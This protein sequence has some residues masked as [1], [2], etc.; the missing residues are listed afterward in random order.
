MARPD[1]EADEL[2]QLGEL[3]FDRRTGELRA[4]DGSIKRLPPQ[5]T[6]LLALLID[7]RGQVATREQIRAHLWPDVAV[8]F[9][10]GLHQCIR[11]IRT[12][13]GDDAK[14]PRFVET[15]PRRGYRLRAEPPPATVSS[16]HRGRVWLIAALAAIAIAAVLYAASRARGGSSSE[17][18]VFAIMSFEHGER[19][20]GEISERILVEL[21]AR[22]PAATVVGPRTT[23]PLRQRGH[24]LREIGAATSATYLINA[25]HSVAAEEPSILVE[26]IRQSDGKHIW[27]RRYEGGRDQ[28]APD[29]IGAAIRV[30]RLR[31]E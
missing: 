12:A 27:V 25:R 19:G 28:I 4:E 2:V 17:V 5:P 11:Q 10:A 18:E 29:V 13:L 20:G 1:A 31:D 3:R 24:S 23:E 30:A 22:L 6:A 8:D 26:L 9:E 21:T 15:V 14:Q 16:R 7:Q